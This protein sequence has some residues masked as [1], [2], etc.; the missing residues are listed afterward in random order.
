MKQG[1]GAQ[2]EWK[3]V[4]LVTREGQEGREVRK[5]KR[6]QGDDIK[7]ANMDD[8]F[9]VKYSLAVLCADSEVRPYLDRGHRASLTRD[10]NK[11]K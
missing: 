5:Q 11:I 2:A 9:F 8:T 3:E 10:K 4:N 1:K 7:G 6:K